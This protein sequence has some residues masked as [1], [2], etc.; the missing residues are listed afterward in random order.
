MKDEKNSLRVQGE[1]M[2]LFLCFFNWALRHE[3]V[4]G[5]WKYSST[6]SL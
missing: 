3:S 4:L 2:K 5:E 6:H 1:N